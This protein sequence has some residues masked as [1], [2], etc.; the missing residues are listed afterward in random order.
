[1]STPARAT[2]SSRA[3]ALPSERREHPRLPSSAQ[4]DVHSVAGFWR[5]TLKDIS[6]GGARL[7]CPEPMG[8]W[9]DTV[10]LSLEDPA[11]VAPR[12]DVPATIVR[13]EA[14]DQGHTIGVRFQAVD[15]AGLARIEAFIRV[16][17]H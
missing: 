2:A 7:S 15:P 16:R 3:T 14:T 1:M 12:L 10:T 4:V 13:T 5:A 8:A 9:G 6:L 11:S 17:T